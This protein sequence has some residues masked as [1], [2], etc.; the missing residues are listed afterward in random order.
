MSYC[1]AVKDDL[2]YL[3]SCMVPASSTTSVKQRDI[4]ILT[5]VDDTTGKFGG[6]YFKIVKN[7][8][9]I[10]NSD[11]YEIDIGFPTKDIV[12]G[13]EVDNQEN[14]SIFYDWQTKLNGTEYVERLNKD[15]SWEKVFA[16]IISS[17][18]ENY[19][20]RTSDSTWWTKI[21]EYP[22]S[23]TIR[24]KGLLRPAILMTHVRLRVLFFGKKHISSG[25]YIVTQQ[26]DS[27][28][29]SGYYT[30]LALT[31]IGGDEEL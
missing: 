18:N 5:I 2:N 9:A 10:Q 17:N 13:F 24:I 3:V 27:V 6:P 26:K 23:A 15:G 4:Y 28:S 25:L 20:T 1:G 30:Q 7:S 22:I 31:R 11:A 8:K 16:P 12:L 21:T 14:Y 19:K 29:E